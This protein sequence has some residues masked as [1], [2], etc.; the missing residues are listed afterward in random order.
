M[1]RAAAAR[2]RR[3]APGQSMTRS[4]SARYGS[5]RSP[6]PKKPRRSS[7]SAGC[8]RPP[9]VVTP[10]RRLL[11]GG[12]MTAVWL[13]NRSAPDWQRRA[14]VIAHGCARC[15]VAVCA[16]C[17]RDRH[18]QR[19]GRGLVGRHR[20]PDALASLTDLDRRLLSLLCEQRVLT[21]TQ[22]ECLQPDVPDR[23]LRYRT[24]GLTRLGLV[25]RSRPYR[26]KGS[27]PF[28]YWPTRAS[29]AFVRGDPL[30]RGGERAAPDP[31]FLN[32]AERLSELTCCCGWRRRP[33][34]C[35][36][37]TSNGNATPARRSGR[38]GASGRVL[39]ERLESIKSGRAAE[40]ARKVSAEHVMWRGAARA[41]KPPSGARG[42]SPSH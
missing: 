19:R 28:H 26:E 7:C 42:L 35:A 17:I 29:D 13:A 22:L 30:P 21:Q 16:D 1:C 23:T 38:T 40:D 31:E 10:R 20:R 41:R 15:A 24:E 33:S 11:C 39:A 14:G 4:G 34:V 8:S 6:L 36:C 18:S 25:G 5:R 37:T 32:H 9:P 12:R 3:C 2:C 27:A